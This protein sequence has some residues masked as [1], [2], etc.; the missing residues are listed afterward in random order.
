MA[1]GQ[2]LSR[3]EVELIL[4]F[5]GLSEELRDGLE[6]RVKAAAA[7]AAKELTQV[8]K[9][10]SG[11]GTET[12]R[13]A[14]TAETAVE[15]VQRGA[16]A[17]TAELDKTA[18]AAARVGV[19]AKKSSDEA[20]DTINRRLLPAATKVREALAAIGERDRNRGGLQGLLRDLAGLPPASQRAVRGLTFTR[21]AIISAIAA[22]AGLA[23]MFALAGGGVAAFAAFTVPTIM[24]VIKSQKEM[25]D[26]W[27][28]LS[29][30]QKIASVSTAN[31]IDQYQTLSEALAPG[32]LRVYNAALT[33]TSELLPR[34]VPIA[35]EVTDAL[36]DAVNALGDGFDTDRAQGFFDFLEQSS[37]GAVTGVVAIVQDAGAAVATLLQA[38][39]P[40][41]P[42]MGGLVSGT[43][44]LVTALSELSPELLQLLV[45]TVALRGPVAALSTA[46]TGGV[47]K[48]K[49]F[50]KETKGA[51]LASK[52]LTAAASA[53]PNV[54]LAG[55][56]ALGIFAI[57][58]ATAKTR[59]EELV[60]SIQAQNLALRNNVAGYENANRVLASKLAPT[61]AA[62]GRAAQALNRDLN[63]NTVALAQAALAQRGLSDVNVAASRAL[64][65]NR[66]SL[67][68]IDSGAK[69][70]AA[71][72][73]I[74][75]QQAIALADAVG[76]DLS[77]GI[78]ESGNL[79][80]GA[81]GKFAAYQAAVQ[82]AQNP[83]LA[84]QAAFANAANEALNLTDRVKAL[85]SAF[86][87]TI[88]PSLAL[89]T[90]TTRVRDAY[91]AANKVLADGNA[92]GQ[93]R[94]TALQNLIG[95]LRDQANAEF[96]ANQ[97][98]DKTST[99]FRNQLPAL[100]ALAGKSREGRALINE[101]RD[102]LAGAKSAAET[103]GG[104]LGGLG[105]KADSAKNG[106]SEAARQAGVLD[107][108][109]QGAAGN[110]ADLAVDAQTV[111]SSAGA[112]A[113]KVANLANSINGLKS[114]TVTVRA[115]T[116]PAQAAVQSF[117]RNTSGQVVDV[118]LRMGRVTAQAG[119]TGGMAEELKPRTFPAF[120][121]GGKLRGPGTGTSDSIL[122]RLSTGEF[123]VNA[124][125]TRRYEDLLRAIN[126]NKFASG[127]KV[128]DQ[129][130][131]F[132]SGGLTRGRN[133]VIDL[134]ELLG[135]DLARG[136]ARS[137]RAINAEL[138]KIS[139]S[140]RGKLADIRRS[141]GGD[142][143][144]DLVS[145]SPEEISRQLRD[146]QR[147]ITSALATTNTRVDTVLVGRLTTLNAALGK[148]AAERDRLTAALEKATQTAAD[149]TDRARSSAAL[150][151]LTDE[152]RATPAG[153]AAALRNRLKV[154]NKFQDDVARLQ[155]RGVNKS[156]IEQLVTGG[157][158]QSG[159][160][161]ATLAQASN[162]T[163]RE[164]S[165]LQ[166]RI[167]L[168]SKTF[169]QQSA[170]FLYD[171][172]VN[173]G[174]GFLAGLKSQQK[175]IAALMKDI[176]KSISSTIRK[177][178][179]IKSPSRRLRVDGRESAR[180][181]LLGLEDMAPAV[182]AAARRLVAPVA[183]PR[184]AAFRP[185][186]ET[187]AAVRPPAPARAS[188]SSSV[189]DITFNNT[190]THVMATAS[191]IVAEQERRLLD[192]IR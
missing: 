94:R 121:A 17:A 74:T 108:R 179:K 98:V 120:A 149:V 176:A 181:Y 93:A 64:E 50:A 5:E 4:N 177:E 92:T 38:L 180:G 107:R 66:A 26:E 51:S 22:A 187:A 190:Y 109:A 100:T 75:T 114:R 127:G 136:L 70:V 87:L 76:V 192:A 72:Y 118:T 33:E 119:A 60:D 123:V 155:R 23:P 159:Q 39:A 101:M 186:R 7:V 13:S 49:A 97:A 8:E 117:I 55:A 162:T 113:P 65:Q 182:E 6:R 135:T 168:D 90:A 48:A 12:Q 138:G 156:L 141:V 142:F 82:A 151:T 2:P 20:A 145:A 15:A 157:P 164:I 86:D 71:T 84:I 24:K 144:R 1:A 112:A 129:L 30:D 42:V 62:V 16:K 134:G 21:Q 140:V 44:Q 115:N 167:N 3:A 137:Q 79:T 153:I 130:P 146:L 110:V 95:S 54:Y 99:A 52:A 128:G 122:A 46:F 191:E 111:G 57:S 175:E 116:G 89:Y 158:D 150:S 178:L 154:I 160:L 166:R 77:R 91:A 163:L 59:G 133:P 165:A 14:R 161:A 78:T 81:A 171:S 68:N 102:A 126:S 169:G 104:A 32:T 105:G 103:A 35:S 31:L 143:V 147:S 88:N 45:T 47:G 61:E 131:R 183:L 19:E 152:E 139:K 53:G 34:L 80:A 184:A 29:D 83:T 174:K 132:A 73:G 148:L 25:A 28:S 172:G 188:A 58:L 124:K 36:V 189:R 106:L 85:Q 40:L 10:A 56:A 170:D 63:A 185:A 69:A 96:T 67:K 125:A 41:A 18:K 173:A 27:A 37:S 11:I 43:F 9:A